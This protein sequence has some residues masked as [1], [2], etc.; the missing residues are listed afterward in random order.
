MAQV[1]AQSASAYPKPTHQQTSLPSSTDSSTSTLPKESEKPSVP[2]EAQRVFAPIQPTK[3]NASK[4]ARKRLEQTQSYGD[5]HGFVYHV[6]SRG[7]RST[8]SGSGEKRESHKEDAEKDEDEDEEE[9]DQYRVGWDGDNDPEDPRSKSTA[10][11]WLVVILLCIGSLCVTCTSSIVPSTFSQTERE[12]GMSSEVATLG[13]TLYVFGL[14]IGPMFLAPLSEFYGRRIIYTVSFGFFLIFLIPCALAQNTETMLIFRFLDGVAGSA[15]LSIAGGTVGDMFTKMTLQAP[16]VVYT[17]SPFMGPEIGPL[18]G[19]FINENTLWRWTFWTLIIWA[20]VVWATIILFVPETYHPVLLRRKAERL[21]KE[22]G[23]SRYYAPIERQERSLGKAIAYSCLR[24][25]QLLLFEPMCLILCVFTAILL[26]ILYLF[27]GAF[28]LIY[29]T[30]YHFTLSQT[31][32]S[33]LGLM[34]GMAIGIMT[35]P[36]WARNYRRLVAKA[37]GTS[38]PEFR[39]PPA[40]AGAVLIPIG[41]FWFAWTARP[42]IHW[43]VSIVGSGVFSMGMLFVYSGVFTFLV[44]AYPLYAASA[45]AANSFARSSFAGAF[46]LFG[47]QMYEKLGFEWASSLLAFLTVVMVPFP[48]LFFRYGKRI[49]GKSKYA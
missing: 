34:A 9:E 20:G 36:Y 19:G 4:E 15:F 44:E 38:Q 1:T 16:M 11:K 48:Y 12:F 29:S 35:D 42:E 26:G 18:I 30:N 40:I 31:G 8:K 14:G 13:L 32:L 41:L 5:G 2:P 25:F 6:Q 24:P 46:P 33:F 49:R 45:L 39:L 47:N 22:T 37:G 28:P 3:S 27:F 21:R 43:M 10:R 23:D 17:A 7:G